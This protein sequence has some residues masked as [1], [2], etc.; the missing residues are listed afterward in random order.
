MFFVHSVHWSIKPSSKTS[1]S[2]FAK[3]PLNIQN[4]QAP[5]L[6]NPPY[7]YIFCE[8]HPRK[9]EMCYTIMALKQLT[10]YYSES[11]FFNCISFL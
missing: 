8:L 5:F 1:P 3:H 7:I 10:S 4:V 11:I 6:G 2:F 9:I